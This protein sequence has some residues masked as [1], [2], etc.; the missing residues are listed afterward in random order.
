MVDRLNWSSYDHSP[1]ALTKLL[2]V[3]KA[4]SDL[5]MTTSFEADSS[6]FIFN[7]IKIKPRG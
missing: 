1:G 2:C 7:F 4:Q 3:Q 5:Y 6:P